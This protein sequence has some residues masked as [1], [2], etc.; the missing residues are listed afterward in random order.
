MRNH[1]MDVARGIAFG[2]MLIHHAFYF[3]D[4]SQGASRPSNIGPVVRMCGTVARHLFIV[5]AGYSLAVQ[6]QQ[7][8]QQGPHDALTSPWRTWRRRLFRCL[9]VGVHAALI[10]LVTYACYPGQWVR[11]GILHFMS[12]AL[13]IASTL[14][15]SAHHEPLALVFIL[16]LLGIPATGTWIDVVSGANPH[17]A[18]LD[19][20]PLASWFPWLWLGVLLGKYFPLPAMSSPK[21]VLSSGLSLMGRNSLM[22]YTAHFVLFCVLSRIARER[23]S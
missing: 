22:L 18:M 9:E 14:M 19:W 21:G 20:F 16:V 8:Y 6:Y 12:V 13:L 2:C 1:T 17:Y 23:L 7:G 11:F 10:S 3:S 4:L 5:I 15:M